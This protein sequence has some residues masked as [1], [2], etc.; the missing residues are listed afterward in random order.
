[1]R[2]AHFFL[3]AVIAS[4]LPATAMAQTTTT[5]PPPP[6]PATYGTSAGQWFASGFVGSNFNASLDNDIDIVD[7]DA[8]AS[9]SSIEFGGNIGYT[10]SR[11]FGVEFLADF[12]PT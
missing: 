7:I 4:G 8:D 10:W 1:M 6:A 11:I 2:T 12:T 9:S 3:A 5:A